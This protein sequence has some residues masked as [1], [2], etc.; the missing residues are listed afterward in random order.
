MTLSKYFSQAIPEGTKSDGVSYYYRCPFCYGH[1]KLEYHTQKRMWHCHKCKKSGRNGQSS[2]YW[3][4]DEVLLYSDHYDSNGVMFCPADPEQTQWTYLQKRGLDD[5][6]IR[7]TQ[8]HAGPSP[9]RCF[10]P[11]IEKEEPIYFVGRVMDTELGYLLDQPR[12]LIKYWNPPIGTFPINKREA[13]WGLNRFDPRDLVEEVIICEGILDAIWLP[14]GVAI[15]GSSLSRQQ[16]TK[17]IRLH[18]ERVVFMLDGDAQHMMARNYRVL[19]Q[20]GCRSLVEHVELPWGRD[21]GYYKQDA[22][23]WLVRRERYL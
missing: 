23:E 4:H 15:L 22:V 7:Q 5:S 1:R 13:V 21:P 8:P 20:A 14:H 6:L 10:L 19:I 12:P 2:S 9:V 16:A 18:P 11:I 17:I 3:G